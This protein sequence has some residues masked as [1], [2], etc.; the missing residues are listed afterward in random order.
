MVFPHL[1]RQVLTL[2]I[3]LCTSAII[4]IGASSTKSFGPCSIENLHS[5]NGC[6]PF[7]CLLLFNQ[8]SCELYASTSLQVKTFLTKVFLTSGLLRV[9]PAL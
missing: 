8:L 2:A 1:I 5:V 7:C 3:H 6:M 4:M 9:F